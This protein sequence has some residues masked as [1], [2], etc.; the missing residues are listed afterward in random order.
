MVV[1]G[2]PTVFNGARRAEASRHVPSIIGWN[3]SA[4]PALAVCPTR[5]LTYGSFATM[6]SLRAERTSSQLR[7]VVV[8]LNTRPATTVIYKDFEGPESSNFDLL[9]SGSNNLRYFKFGIIIFI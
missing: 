6:T 4:W 9:V 3:S 2:P 8:T 7:S 5:N 1:H